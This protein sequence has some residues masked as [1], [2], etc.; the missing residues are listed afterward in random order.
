M[1]LAVFFLRVNYASK[2]HKYAAAYRPSIIIIIIVTII[3]IVIVIIIVIIIIIII[4]FRLM[5]L[6]IPILLPLLML[7]PANFVKGLTPL[8]CRMNSRLRPISCSSLVDSS[9]WYVHC[10]RCPIFSV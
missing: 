1:R 3:I 9:C 8:R 4:I 7:D 2:L 6:I 10:L 5:L